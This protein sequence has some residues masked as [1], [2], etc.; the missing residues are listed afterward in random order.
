MAQ[1][2]S[3]REGIQPGSGVSGLGSNEAATVARQ[4]ALQ[5]G[6][7]NGSASRRYPPLANG[8]AKAAPAVRNTAEKLSF[9]W[10]MAVI[11][12]FGTGLNT[13]GPY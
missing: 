3:S 4:S 8:F 13:P 2:N 7:D 11:G 6:S 1:F 10:F 9:L 5:R 12:A